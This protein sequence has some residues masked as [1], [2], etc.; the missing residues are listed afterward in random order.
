MDYL[1]TRLASS[2]VCNPALGDFLRI[3]T[4]RTPFSFHTDV[5]LLHDSARILFCTHSTCGHQLDKQPLHSDFVFLSRQHIFHPNPLHTISTQRPNTSTTI[6]RYP[7]TALPYPPPSP[8]APQPVT[9]LAQI[10]PLS[11]PF[12]SSSSP[13]KSI[14]LSLSDV[15]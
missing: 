6:L 8:L 2:L 14:L 15:L 1:S 12:L 10:R 4:K 7:T 13:S 3:L 11:L 9:S 5:L